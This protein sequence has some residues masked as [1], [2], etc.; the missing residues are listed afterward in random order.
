[1]SSLTLKNIPNEAKCKRII[2]KLATGSD[3]CTKCSGRIVFKRSTT[4]GWCSV[5]RI[6]IRPKAATWLKNSK[7]SYQQIF[8]LIH[9]W[10]TRLS[11]GATR[12]ATGLSYPTI[13]R[14]YARFREHIP[15]DGGE[16]LSGVI[17]V[18]ESWFGKKKH[19]G[20]TIVIGGIEVD[21]RRLR[22]QVIPDTEQ[23]SIE[24]FLEGWVDRSS[25]LITDASTSYNGVEW[26]GYSR[27][28][29]NHSAGHFGDSNHIECIWSAM[30]RH[31]RK[32]YGC[33]PTKH[34]KVFLHEWEARHNQRSLFESPLNYLKATIV[35]L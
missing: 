31:L 15:S 13:Q 21:T 3:R 16:V 20:Q 11:P 1:M 25:H 26:L 35:P 28:I 19:G 6:K 8:T 12:A 29:Y 5:C 17:A 4:Y 22:L 34:L 24:L 27:D 10:Q 2:H 9:Y 18:D 33:I 7:I 32:L 14:W 23:D 30:K